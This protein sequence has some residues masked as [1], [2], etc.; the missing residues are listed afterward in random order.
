MFATD[1]PVLIFNL[2]YTN[3]LTSSAKRKA[4]AMSDLG[5]P[6]F[7]WQDRWII[8]RDGVLILCEKKEVDSFYPG[9]LVFFNHFTGCQKSFLLLVIVVHRCSP[10]IRTPCEQFPNVLEFQFAR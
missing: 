3:K 10:W 7:A 6:Q 5:R 9:K 1:S 2:V 8:V 4:N